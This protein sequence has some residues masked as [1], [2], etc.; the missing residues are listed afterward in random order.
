M[1]A[2][3][4]MCVCVCVCARAHVRKCTHMCMWVLSEARCVYEY[5]QRPEEG[6]YIQKRASK[7][8]ELGFQ[9]FLSHQ[10]WV[11]GTKLG[12]SENAASDLKQ[13]AIS[14]TSMYVHYVSWL[15][16]PSGSRYVQYQKGI[17]EYSLEIFNMWG[18]L[19][20]NLVYFVLL[21]RSSPANWIQC[22]PST[23]ET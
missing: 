21:L 8:L 20:R 17:P 18:L 16:H 15:W 5:F 6:I 14:S 22:P 2:W 1:V 13:I 12:S 10:T 7:S 19:R 9:L 3:R 23:M 4:E 11:L